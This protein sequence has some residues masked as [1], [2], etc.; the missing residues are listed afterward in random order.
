MYGV[1]LIGKTEREYIPWQKEA[2]AAI[3]RK[4]GAN[5]KAFLCLSDI[6]VV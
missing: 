3:Q 5:D 1:A 2:R 6:A 4:N